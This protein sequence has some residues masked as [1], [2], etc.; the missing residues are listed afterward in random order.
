MEKYRRDL[1]T[2]PQDRR[3]NEYTFTENGL[4]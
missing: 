1:Y 4:H 3:R 2:N